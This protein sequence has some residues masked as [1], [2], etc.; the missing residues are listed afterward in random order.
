MVADIINIHQPHAFMRVSFN[1]A[2]VSNFLLSMGR[3]LGGRGFVS[4]W[5]VTVRKTGITGHTPLFPMPSW[6]A[7]S[8]PLYGQQQVQTQTAAVD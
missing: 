7:L 8:F 3:L 6:A 5:S 2:G 1:S 4:A